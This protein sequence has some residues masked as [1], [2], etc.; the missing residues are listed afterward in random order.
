MAVKSFVPGSGRAKGVPNR[1]TTA[2]RDM[3]LGALDEV[4]GQSY[5]VQQA[6]QNPKAFLGLIGRCLPKDL[7]I[8]RNPEQPRVIDSSK[9][10]YDE[11]QQLRDMILR[12][13][14][15]TALEHEGSQEGLGAAIAESGDDCD[16]EL[17][18]TTL[19]EIADDGTIEIDV[20]V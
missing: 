10:S 13:A 12:A 19:E 8:T 3:I 2:L 7:N 20:N 1:L 15:P 6:R 17:P 11:R 9:L 14:E 4:G 18:Q 16:E 5:L